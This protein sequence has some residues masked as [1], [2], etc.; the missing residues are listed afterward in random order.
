MAEF[1]VRNSMNPHKAVKFGITYRQLVDKSNYDGELM[2]VLEIA[3]DEPDVTTSGVI[4]P[5]FVTLVDLEDIDEEIEKAVVA[6]SEKIDWTPLQSDVRPPFIDSIYPDMYITGI[7][8]NVKVTIK[9]LHP[10]AG[11]DIDS[12][13]MFINDIEVT[14]DLLFTGDEFDYMVEWRTPTRVYAQIKY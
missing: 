12:I 11:I 13:Q 3:T 10:S 9:D 6:I 8:S 4:P 7:H 2:W 5:Y 1:I 14:P